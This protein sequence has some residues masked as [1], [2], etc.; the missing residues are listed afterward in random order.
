MAS[1]SV[2]DKFF[3]GARFL[4]RRSSEFR[5]KLLDKNCVEEKL[6]IALNGRINEQLF[7]H[8]SKLFKMKN[9]EED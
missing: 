7:I 5:G 8:N 4:S 2:H 6:C 1:Y 9:R 3:S